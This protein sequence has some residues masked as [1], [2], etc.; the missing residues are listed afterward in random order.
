[1]LFATQEVLYWFHVPYFPPNKPNREI[2]RGQFLALKKSF[3]FVLPSSKARPFLRSDNF[4][5][6]DDILWLDDDEEDNIV[7]AQL[8]KLEN[9]P[10]ND[11]VSAE[12]W[13]L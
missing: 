3:F 1:M 9:D 5:Q 8:I 6:N 7:L 10:Y 13:N 2:R 4:L 11:Q 12:D